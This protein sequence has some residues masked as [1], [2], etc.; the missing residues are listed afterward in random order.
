MQLVG[1]QLIYSATDLVGFL[2]C[3]HFANLERAAVGG[4]LKRPI[5]TDPVLDRM[6]NR[7]LLHEQR[8][9]AER[10]AEGLRIVSIPIDDSVSSHERITN[11]SGATIDPP[12]HLPLYADGHSQAEFRRSQPEWFSSSSRSTRD[13]PQL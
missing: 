7:G 2:E 3:R 1:D 4:H 6:A 12:K 10:T 5:R 8:F 13:V 11:G 9:L